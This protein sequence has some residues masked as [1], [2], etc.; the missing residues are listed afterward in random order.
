MEHL[1]LDKRLVRSALLISSHLL[2]YFQLPD[3]LNAITQV[4]PLAPFPL[5]TPTSTLILFHITTPAE[6][7][8]RQPDPSQGHCCTLITGQSCGTNAR[9]LGL[10]HHCCHVN[11]SRISIEFM[12]TVEGAK[13]VVVRGD[14]GTEEMSQAEAVR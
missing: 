12:Q 14:G 7:K 10:H 9:P 8:E 5:H 6:A 2:S 3:N 1:R 11:Y 13:A 4:P